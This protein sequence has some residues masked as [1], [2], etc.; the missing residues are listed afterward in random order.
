VRR[1]G[2]AVGA[3]ESSAAALEGGEG[4]RCSATTAATAAGTGGMVGDVAYQQWIA[5]VVAPVT[6]GEG[7]NWQDTLSEQ[8]IWKGGGGRHV[9]AQG[10]C[11]SCENVSV[12][13]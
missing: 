6:R 9:M 3:G 1:G 5:D 7:R 12:A 13:T 11:S 8:C 2:G 10:P 4:C